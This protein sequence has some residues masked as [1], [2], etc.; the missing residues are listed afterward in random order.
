M[1]TIILTV[2]A[3]IL[4]IWILPFEFLE[5]VFG[6]LGL[7][8]IIFLVSVF[9]IHTPFASVAKGFIPT[10]PA[11]NLAV[12]LYFALGIISSSMMPYEVYFYS[13][14]GIEEKWKPKDLLNNKLTAI[15]GM[16]LGASLAISL[17]ILG[18]QIFQPLSITPQLH[19][20]SALL[21]SLPFGKVGFYLAILGI[22]FTLIGAATE[23]CLAGAYNIAQYAGWPWGRYTK[24]EKTPHFTIVWIVILFMAFFIMILGIDPVELVEYAVVFS[25]VALPF[26]YYPILKV[27]GDKK[28]MKQHKNNSVISILGWIYF[29]LI[30]L[31]A[32]AAIPLMIIS[33]MGNG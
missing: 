3:L 5:K 15:I 2:G 26:T 18:A 31:I 24:P 9:S 1:P 7:L 22:A 12:Y 28:V 20:T 30:T 11:D 8:M 23:T 21:A 17:I 32:I 16:V 19:G 6:L 13:S 25:V 27:S 10:L 14:G 4:L 29:G 33:N